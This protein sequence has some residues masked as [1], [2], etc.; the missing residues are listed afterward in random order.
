MRN[1]GFLAKNLPNQPPHKH[2]FSIVIPAVCNSA[3]ILLHGSSTQ[4]TLYCLWIPY[5]GII[6]FPVTYVVFFCVFMLMLEIGQRGW[7]GPGGY[8]GC[9]NPSGGLR[10]NAFFLVDRG[11]IQWTN[12][13]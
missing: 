6:C 4:A 2:N 1:R 12:W 9:H 8:L 10:G 5:F 3:H 7:A 11:E 13:M